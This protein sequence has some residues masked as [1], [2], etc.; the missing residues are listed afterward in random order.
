[1]AAAEDPYHLLL[2]EQVE[3]VVLVAAGA[4]MQQQETQLQELAVQAMQVVIHQ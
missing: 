1:V 2:L 3:Q 4:D